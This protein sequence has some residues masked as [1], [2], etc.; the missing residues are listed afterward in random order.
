M[1]PVNDSLETSFSSSSQS[2]RPSRN[3]SKPKRFAIEEADTESHSESD[4]ENER[5]RRRRKENAFSANQEVDFNFNSPNQKSSRN[6]K[7]LQKS[8]LEISRPIVQVTFS[9]ENCATFSALQHA[10]CNIQVFCD[11]LIADFLREGTEAKQECVYE[12]I[13]LLFNA[14]GTKFA[15][16]QDIWQELAIPVEIIEHIEEQVILQQQP[17]AVESSFLHAFPWDSKEREMK[18]FT[19]AFTEFWNCLIQRAFSSILTHDSFLP[20]L[21]DWVCAMTSCKYRHFRF[22]STLAVFGIVGGLAKG[23]HLQ[24]AQ[25]ESAQ[26]VKASSTKKRGRKP[27]ASFDEASI[28]SSIEFAQMQINAMQINALLDAVFVHR[29]RDID[30][31]IRKEAINSLSSWICTLPAH[32]GEQISLLSASLADERPVVREAT[33]EA[34]IS[35]SAVPEAHSTLRAFML[36]A[37]NK[38]RII[39][40]GLYDLAERVK[41]LSLN[42]IQIVVCDLKM[43]NLETSEL[44]KLKMLAFHLNSQVKL[45]AMPIV[46]HF[47]EGNWSLSMDGLVSFLQNCDRCNSAEIIYP[48]FKE[49]LAP[50]L[51]IQ[52]LLECAGAGGIKVKLLLEF[53]AAALKEDLASNS[54]ALSVDNFIQLLH[55]TKEHSA[56]ILNVLLSMDVSLWTEKLDK[57]KE[58]V[59]PQLLNIIT[60]SGERAL[61]KKGI[62]V[63]YSLAQNP[64]LASAIQGQKDEFVGLLVT[65]FASQCNSA[66]LEED[67]ICEFSCWRIECICE[68]EHISIDF[69]FAFLTK[70]LPLGDL[71]E[72]TGD[73]ETILISCMKALFKSQLHLN[74]FKLPD[75]LFDLCFLAFSSTS[76]PKLQS[77]LASLLADHF[78]FSQTCDSL[79]VERIRQVVM[80]QILSSSSSVEEAQVTTLIKLAVFQMIPIRGSLNALSF[81]MSSQQHWTERLEAL[82]ECSLKKLLMFP[83]P[84]A[85][86]VIEELLLGIEKAF[87]ANQSGALKTALVVSSSAKQNP[88]LFANEAF[89]IFLGKTISNKNVSLAVPFIPFLNKEQCVKL[90]AEADQLK[91]TWESKQQQT[92]WEEFLAKLKVRMAQKSVTGAKR[93]RKPKTAAVAS[94]VTELEEVSVEQ[95]EN[96][97]ASSPMLEMNND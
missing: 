42:F 53:L 39:E 73:R 8:K 21:F 87:A 64:L 57:L 72:G 51:V 67:E 36:T 71:G 6:K 13:S 48:A 40:L 79:L 34:L 18:K 66:R 30:Q 29:I 31:K 60:G 88:Q 25:L 45:A 85:Q 52:K 16:Q 2:A 80:G 81:Y 55:I 56:S 9:H 32:F 11:D 46:C 69:L 20:V 5:P 3:K 14:A 38:S 63:L 28:A 4:S 86:E 91:A 77:M 22:V 37:N 50:E 41:V 82:F 62:E 78:I 49:L 47:I 96:P 26:Q 27:A 10:K 76:W 61:I 93:G 65:E 19:K 74:A 89:C 35:I 54:K 44:D 17:E 1:A 7:I 59:I 83:L 90:L 94:P 43:L 75:S 15:S 95:E 58:Q 24:Q 23:I 84:A 70:L 12:L 92:E 68:W 33:L 97:F